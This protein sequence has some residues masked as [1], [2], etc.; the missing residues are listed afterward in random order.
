[1]KLILASQSPRRKQ[2]LNKLGAEF[3]IIVP[4]NEEVFDKTVSIDD[5]IKKIALNKAL[6]VYKENSGFAVLGAD[7][8]VVF[9][10]E[11]IG[12]PK[13]EED[14]YRILKKLNGNTHE[15]KTAIALIGKDIFYNECVTSKV[16]FNDMTDDFILSYIKEKSPLDKAGA[17]GIQDGGVVKSFCGSYDNIVGLP[18][19]RVGEILLKEGFIKGDKNVN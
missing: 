16:T 18:T 9:S 6:E 7:S 12:K 1:M 13:D 8:V 11:V 2:L 19:E 4:K 15:V 10:G 5:A 17:Y 3:T 14:A